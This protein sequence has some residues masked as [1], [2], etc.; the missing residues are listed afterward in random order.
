MAALVDY[1]TCV[2]A[3]GEDACQD[4]MK[5][6]MD[7]SG[8][9]EMTCRSPCVAL[10][11]QRG[12]GARRQWPQTVRRTEAASAEACSA[13][14][15]TLESILG[16]ANRSHFDGKACTLYRA[17]NTIVGETID[18]WKPSETVYYLGKDR[19]HGPVPCEGVPE[20]PDAV[21]GNCKKSVQGSKK[22]R[23]KN[24]KQGKAAA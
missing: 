22:G 8:S 10:E 2:N 16:M 15:S 6:T 7:L 21:V 23:Y 19:L 18:A 12:R 11:G 5:L 4:A 9:Y 1:Q 17:S 14:A 3:N 24:S 20:G 13:E